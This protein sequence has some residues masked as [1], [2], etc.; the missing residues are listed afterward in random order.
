MVKICSI[1]SGSNGNCY[2][3]EHSGKAVLVDC[4]IYFKRFNERM[5]RLALDSSI[6][7]GVFVTHE[8]ADHVRGIRIINKKLDVPI[9][10]TSKTYEAIF[11]KF[12][13][14]NPI[15]FD[16]NPIE[17]DKDFVVYPVR[18]SHNA[19]DPYSFRIKVGDK[20]IG[21]FTD[22]GTA[23]QTLMKHF[24]M[25]NAVFLESNYDENMLQNGSYPI[26]LKRH[27]ASDVGHLSNSQAFMLLNYCAS[28][29]LTHVIISHV[30]QENNTHELIMEKFK[31]LIPN[32]NFSIAPRFSEGEI[33]T[34]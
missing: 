6:I 33:F 3:I 34:L 27:I 30:S 11:Q 20:N 1:A 7:K 26:Y 18:K 9:Y 4:G 19:A 24:S 23:D 16:D 29:N 12:R 14:C 21:V 8:H 28:N 2:Y 31:E 17:I 22:I 32:Y 13:P 15:F 10:I 25:C 5:E